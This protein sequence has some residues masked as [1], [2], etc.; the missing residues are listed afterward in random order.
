MIKRERILKFDLDIKG[1]NFVIW[2]S[3]FDIKDFFYVFIVG[4]DLEYGIG[5][6]LDIRDVDRDDVSRYSFLFYVVFIV[7]DSKN[8]GL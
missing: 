3:D 4:G 2:L 8:F 5:R 7:M 1:E 6:V